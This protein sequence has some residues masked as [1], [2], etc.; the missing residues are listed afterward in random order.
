MGG[1]GTGKSTFM[2]QLLER[3][4]FKLGALEDLHARIGGHGRAVTLRGHAMKNGDTHGYYLGVMREGLF[5]GTDALERVSHGPAADWVRAG[6]LPPVIVSEGATLAVRPFLNALHEHTDA[7]I[8]AFR[9][10]PW[11]HELRLLERGTGQAESFVASS[12]TRTENLARDLTKAGAAVH[13][14]D[15]DDP[16]SWERALQSAEIHLG[17]LI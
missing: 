7:L 15:A 11:V 10:E 2:A 16:H 8:L 6:N 17:G 9:C 12:I 13:W 4:D 14:V 3:M 5:P 1:A